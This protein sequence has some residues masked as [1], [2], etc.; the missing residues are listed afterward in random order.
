MVGLTRD[1]AKGTGAWLDIDAGARDG[2]LGVSWGLRLGWIGKGESPIV[3]LTNGQFAAQGRLGL[4]RSVYAWNA[5]WPGELL[6]TAD[7]WGAYDRRFGRK[8]GLEAAPRLG[9]R[10]LLGYGDGIRGRLRFDVAPGLMSESPTTAS[11]AWLRAAFDVG[12]ISL[13]AWMQ[14]RMGCGGADAHCGRSAGL[15]LGYRRGR[16]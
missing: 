2:V 1:E 8:T 6:L 3:G 16:K 14:L 4:A 12:P 5:I 15:A 13:G 10:L 7:L 9:I 11:A